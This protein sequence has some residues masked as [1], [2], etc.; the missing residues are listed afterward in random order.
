MRVVYLRKGYSNQ[1]TLQELTQHIMD[2]EGKETASNSSQASFHPLSSHSKEWRQDASDVSF[3]QVL[4]ARLDECPLA[5]MMD[6]VQHY[7][8]DYL[9]LILQQGQEMIASGYQLALML[10]GTPEM[11]SFLMRMSATYMNRCQTIRINNLSVEE[12]SQ[13]L[14]K[15]FLDQDIKVSDDALAFMIDL[16][17][18]YPYFVQ[19]V[20]QAVW[21]KMIEQERQD[22]DLA[23]AQQSKVVFER[24]RNI[25]YD[26]IYGEMY[27]AKLIPFA[28]QVV[29]ILAEHEQK[30]RLETLVEKLQKRNP[31][32]KQDRAV[33]VAE[34]L[35]DWG[36]MWKEVDWLI[37]GAPSLASYLQSRIGEQA[38]S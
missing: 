26:S 8:A 7:D 35:V 3:R 13:A 27:R 12:T 1:G 32:M 9:A 19:V 11:E 37:P 10:V 29:D 18:N 23:L 33:E 17:D 31:D 28:R 38:N 22:V 21:E 20:G 2:G 16:S 5:I 6:E 34:G 4:Q 14:H 30:L 15:P 25:F 24:E 36:F